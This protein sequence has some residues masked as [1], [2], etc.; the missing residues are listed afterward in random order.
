MSYSKIKKPVIYSNL[1]GIK[2]VLGDAVHYINPMN[3]NEISLAINKIFNDELY[4]NNLIEK[5]CDK[6]KENKKNFNFSKFFEIIDNF[7]KYQKTW[8]MSN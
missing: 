7:R 1:P 6:F 3:P 4:R 8:D 5:G 2:D